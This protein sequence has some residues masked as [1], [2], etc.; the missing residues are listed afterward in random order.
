MERRYIDQ[1]HLRFDEVADV[2]FAVITEAEVLR[3]YD[4]KRTGKGIWL[5]LQE[6]WQ[7]RFKE[8]LLIAG[9]SSTGQS[10]Y[11]LAWGEPNWLTPITEW[12]QSA[13]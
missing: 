7:E 6:R 10:Y 8:P 3:W 4:R 9:G 11:V 1:L 12:S 13:A 2:G 5:D